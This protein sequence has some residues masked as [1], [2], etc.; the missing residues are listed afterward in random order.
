MIIFKELTFEKGKSENIITI[1]H[2]QINQI[3]ALIT[4]KE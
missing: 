1:K 3:S 4:Q 2:L